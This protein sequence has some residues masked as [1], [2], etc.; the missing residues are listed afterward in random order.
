[1]TPPLSGSRAQVLHY[2]TQVVAIGRHNGS[3]TSAEVVDVAYQHLSHPHTLERLARAEHAA[4]LDAEAEVSRLR[5]RIHRLEAAGIPAD[6]QPRVVH[7]PAVQADVITRISEGEAAQAVADQL[8]L[9]LRVVRNHIT[10]ARKAIGADSPR[11]AV[12]LVAS[13]AVQV[14]VRPSRTKAA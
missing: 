8:H 11:R 13:G 5:G 14:K 4:R 9:S 2:L 12:A 6:G 1:M 10:K 3:F 7:L